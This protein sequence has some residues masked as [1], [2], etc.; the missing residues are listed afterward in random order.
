[1]SN[2]NFYYLDSY[3]Y[4][5]FYIVFPL[6]EFSSFFCNFFLNY[7]VC[8]IFPI[9]ITQELNYLF[10]QDTT[11]LCKHFDSNFIEHI[12]SSRLSIQDFVFRMFLINEISDVYIKHLISMNLSPGNLNND[13]ISHLVSQVRNSWLFY[14]RKL[15]I[16]FIYR[17]Y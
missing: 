7:C 9:F 12:Y 1:M 3:R 11:I 15:F 10:C 8:N 14:L 4:G 17:F 16:L 5:S 13:V 2:F 6:Y